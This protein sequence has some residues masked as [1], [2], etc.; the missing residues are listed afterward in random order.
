MATP[1]LTTLAIPNLHARFSKSLLGLFVL[2]LLRYDICCQNST[3]AHSGL[4]PE[5]KKRLKLT[6][7]GVKSRQSQQSHE[8]KVHC[9]GLVRDKL[10]NDIVAWIT[11]MEM[12]GSVSLKC[13]YRD[14]ECRYCYYYGKY[15]DCIIMADASLEIVKTFDIDMGLILVTTNIGRNSLSDA[16]LV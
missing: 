5:F 9:T 1:V 10:V 13:Q 15:K 8:S 11:E 12:K 2:W 7:V 4:A 6:Q 3:T 14:Y 16:Q